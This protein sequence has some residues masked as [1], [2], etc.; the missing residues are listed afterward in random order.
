M[1]YWSSVLG[2]VVEET[3]TEDNYVDYLNFAC[4]LSRGR[5]GG[6]KRN[7]GDN[8]GVF[9]MAHWGMTKGGGNRG[10]GGGGADTSTL[11]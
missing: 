4:Q 3:P 9:L 2:L 6:N 5:R 11:H 7:F 1:S 10:A 8:I